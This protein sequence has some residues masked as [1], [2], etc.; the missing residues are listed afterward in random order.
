MAA[1]GDFLVTASN[2]QALFS[3]PPA[4]E[5]CLPVKATKADGNPGTAAIDGPTEHSQ[6]VAPAPTSFPSPCS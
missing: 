6:I 3:V 2:E 4:S 5:F 1:S